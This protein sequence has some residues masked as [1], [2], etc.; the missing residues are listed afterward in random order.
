MMTTDVPEQLRPR[1]LDAVM[2]HVPFDGWSRAAVSAAARD[3][4]LDPGLVE[5]AFPGGILEMIGAYADR[6][7]R[8]AV[9][10]LAQ[11]PLD[12]LKVRE[13]VALAVRLRVETM[14]DHREA[15][16]RALSFLSLPQHAAAGARLSWRTADVLWRALHDPSTDFNYYSK[17]A[18]LA[19]VY[20]ATVLYW[21][22]DESD[23]WSETWA[24]LDRR[25]EDVM[26]IEKAKARVRKYADMLPEF[27][28]A[29]GK[30]RYRG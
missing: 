15:V 10:G 17:R 30:M 18:I 9:N 24:F 12:R 6:A 27:S 7:D 3:L 26:K 22:N 23:G 20:S 11:C 16:R 5:L 1:I 4:G 14:V 2:R 28:R 21:L 29:L 8:Q 25:I 13:R 19:A